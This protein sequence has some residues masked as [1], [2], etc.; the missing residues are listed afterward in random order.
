MSFLGL[1]KLFSTVSNRIETVSNSKKQEQIDALYN[2][3]ATTIT[4][5]A[6]KVNKINEYKKQIKESPITPKD[7]AD[8]VSNADE[9]DSVGF[10]NERESVL[11]DEEDSD[12]E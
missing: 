12:E 11:P 2:E 10:E 7:D 3:I 1:D 4:E 8:P 5:L 9:Q 6:N